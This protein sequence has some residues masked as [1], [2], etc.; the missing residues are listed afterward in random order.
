MLPHF[1][2]GMVLLNFLTD[3]GIPDTVF[4]LLMP[5]DME[6]VWAMSVF[7]IF[8]Y[9]ALYYYLDAV[10]PNKYGI[11]YSPCFCIPKAKRL[12]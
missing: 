4:Q 11:A 2:Y 7:T 5:H 12:C 1:T 9:L 8:F 3:E 10:I 6:T